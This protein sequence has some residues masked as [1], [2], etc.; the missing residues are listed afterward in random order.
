MGLE[1]AKSYAL[2]LR[3]QALNALRPFDAAAEPLRELARY[4][5]DRRH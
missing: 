2:E 3:D 4:I 5:V 1:R